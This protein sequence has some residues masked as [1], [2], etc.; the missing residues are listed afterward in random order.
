MPLIDKSFLLL[1]FKK[2]DSFFLAHIPLRQ[3]MAEGNVA[4][5]LGVAGPVSG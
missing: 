3:T 4:R 5:N 1:F 2:E